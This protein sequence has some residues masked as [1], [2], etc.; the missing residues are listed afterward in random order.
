MARRKYASQK[1]KG[2]LSLNAD[3]VKKDIK[4]HV[5]ISSSDTH[6]NHVVGEVQHSRFTLLHVYNVTFTLR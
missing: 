5:Y 1:L 3:A 4:Y 6:L 2:A